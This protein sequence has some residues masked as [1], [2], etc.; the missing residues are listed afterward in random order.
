MHNGYTRTW[1]IQDVKKGCCAWCGEYKAMLCRREKPSTVARLQSGCFKQRH[2]DGEDLTSAPG[3]EHG[4]TLE[5]PSSLKSSPPHLCFPH[6]HSSHLSC[7]NPSGL[8]LNLPAL[9]PAG[10]SV[11][12]RERDPA[13]HNQYFGNWYCHATA[14]MTLAEWRAALEAQGY[15]RKKG[16]PP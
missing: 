2:S 6:L 1:Q 11:C 15:G 5:L 8:C 16:A 12:Q 4:N 3:R 14:T 13:T 7:L 9:Q 10:A